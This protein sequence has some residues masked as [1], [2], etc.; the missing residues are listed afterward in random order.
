MGRDYRFPFGCSGSLI[1]SPNTISR[2]IGI[3]NAKV[4]NN[5]SPRKPRSKMAAADHS[6]GNTNP[7]R[8]AHQK[9]SLAI[10]YLGIDF[11]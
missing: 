1:L 10:L 7:F 3:E 9:Y 11:Y 5:E 8:Y 6:Y 4:K 2:P